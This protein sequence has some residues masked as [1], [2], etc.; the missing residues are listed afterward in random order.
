[1]RI[2]KTTNTVKVVNRAKTTDITVT[3]SEVADDVEGRCDQSG[4]TEDD[5]HSR[6]HQSRTYAVGSDLQCLI[7]IA[8]IMKLLIEAFHHQYGIFRAHSQEPEHPEWP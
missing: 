5:G 2:V 7:G 3:S 6:C 4:K 8:N 1:M